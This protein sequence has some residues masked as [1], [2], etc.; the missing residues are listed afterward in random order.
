M[1]RACTGRRDV[2]GGAGALDMPPTGGPLARLDHFLEDSAMTATTDRT[3]L[4]NTIWQRQYAQGDEDIDQGI[5]RVARAIAEVDERPEASETEFRELMADNR[6]WP[7][8]RV[9]AGAATL[10]GNLLNCFVQDGSPH[11][12]GTTKAVLATA[13]KLALVTKVGGGNGVNLDDLFPKSR[14]P[15]QTGKAYITIGTT[16]RDYQK[17][18]D[19]TYMDLTRGE[20]VTRPYRFI[21]FLEP[22]E[23]DRHR[24]AN[25]QALSLEM[26]DSVEGI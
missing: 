24:A 12:P 5:T 10:H 21:S 11:E 2:L 15:R 17:V 20:Y 4:K 19:G 26:P 16:H 7:G 1:L 13:R 23:F 8:G 9:L 22:A 6:F 25:A 3:G 18:H 14:N